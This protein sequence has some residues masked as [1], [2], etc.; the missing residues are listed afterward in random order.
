MMESLLEDLQPRLG[1][2]ASICRSGSGLGGQNVYENTV[3]Y[4]EMRNSLQIFKSLK[5]KSLIPMVIPGI[6]KRGGVSRMQVYP[7]M[8]LIT[9]GIIF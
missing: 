2:N 7:R 8:Y 3:G 5:K 6:E 9:K 4:G 1:E